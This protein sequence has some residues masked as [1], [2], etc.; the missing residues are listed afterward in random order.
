M[1]AAAGA[2]WGAPVSAR[3]GSVVSAVW[4]LRSIGAQRPAWGPQGLDLDSELGN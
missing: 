2:A 1:A 3:S 4:M